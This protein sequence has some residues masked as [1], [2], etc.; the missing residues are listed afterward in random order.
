MESEAAL[1]TMLYVVHLCN[2]LVLVLYYPLML[3]M[4]TAWQS[5]LPLHGWSSNAVSSFRAD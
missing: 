4:A 3:N 1:G 5:H 2:L